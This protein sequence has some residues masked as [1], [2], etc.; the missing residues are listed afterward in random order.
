M[1]AKLNQNQ[2]P[3]TQWKGMPATQVTS[4]R[5]K[6]GTLFT[7]SQIT[8]VF[9][10]TYIP[11]GTSYRINKKSGARPLKIY[12]REMIVDLSRN[13]TGNPRT[14]TSIDELARPNGYLVNSKQEGLVNYLDLELPNSKYENGTQTCNDA[15]TC[16]VTNAL[17]RLRS[18]GNVK[19][20]NALFPDTGAYYTSTNQYLVGRNRTFA[21][22][23]YSLVR[24]GD[25]SLL[26]TNPGTTSFDKYNLNVFTKNN[27]FSTNG[28]MHTSKYVIYPVYD[29][30]GTANNGAGNLVSYEYGPNDNY[31]EYTWLDGAVYDIH[32]PY[33]E[34]T[35]DVFNA[36]FVDGMIQNKHYYVNT[37]TGAKI[38]LMRFIYNTVQCKVEFQSLNSAPYATNTTNYM[39][40]DG[41][42]YSASN[43]LPQLIVPPGSAIQNAFG[44]S[45]G[46][47]PSVDPNSTNFPN[48]ANYA[49][50]SNIPHGLYPNYSVIH[51]KPNNPKFAHQGAVSSSSLVSRKKYDTIT[52][53][54][55]T[56]MGP[57]GSNVAN[58]LSYSV[59]ENIN[60]YKAKLGYPLTSTPVFKVGC[61]N[62]LACTKTKSSNGVSGR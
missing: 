41:H 24:Y 2:V 44:L 40:G 60:N 57:F 46:S 16:M 10:S 25:A 12:R 14:T 43:V 49:I 62:K 39:S 3:Y 20:Q 1:S 26:N 8:N 51:Y 33:G 6:N 52:T 18:S 47:Y 53:T 34:Y 11:K 58:A 4:T 32:F 5:Q 42:S 30:M 28:I 50:T 54:A 21:Q 15:N 9:R 27:A 7:D 29:G 19:R 56:Y 35:I 13:C 38:F 23:Q 36:R 48:D 31:I 59:T 22:N 55:E 61:A 37:S 45:S 17:R